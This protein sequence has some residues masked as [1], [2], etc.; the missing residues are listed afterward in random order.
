M[1]AYV[2]DFYKLFVFFVDYYDD[3]L[4]LCYRQTAGIDIDLNYTH[5]NVRT[6]I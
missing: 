2:N 6:S 1:L 5:W 4:K 3:D